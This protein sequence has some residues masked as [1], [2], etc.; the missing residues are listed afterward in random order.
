VA[1]AVTILTVAG[2]ELRRESRPVVEDL[3]FSLSRGERVA[4]MG[5]SGTGKTTILRAIAGLERYSRGSI[6]IGVGGHSRD[7]ARTDRHR[8]LVGI[9]FQFHHLFA[10]LT[11]LENVWM[12]PVH[13]LRA[14][15]A[16]AERHARELLD[17]L[18]V[19]HRATAMPHELSGGEA[20]RVAIARALAVSPP[21]LLMDEPTAS[22]DPARRGELAATVR[23]L[24]EDGTTLLI[25]THDAEFA[26]SCTQRVL[27]LEHGRL[28]RQGAPGA[29]L[30]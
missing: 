25:A 14:P 29:V 19:A 21:L 13:V 7:A 26:R 23:Q 15:R 16:A 6:E 2:L 11:A 24:S 10:N 28:T 8:S 5:A 9:V 27:V 20:Q 4:L 3:S 30:A 22:L 18:G 17:R 12:A 1:P